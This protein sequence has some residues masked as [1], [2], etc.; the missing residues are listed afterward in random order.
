[1]PVCGSHTGG[2][3]S[4]FVSRGALR[5]LRS[6]KVFFEN[7]LEVYLFAIFRGSPVFYTVRF[8]DKAILSR[9]DGI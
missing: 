4:A 9:K 7:L 6:L 1:M 2:G 5:G 3:G 8:S